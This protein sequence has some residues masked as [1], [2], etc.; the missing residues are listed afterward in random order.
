MILFPRRSQVA[1]AT[2]TST[3]VP[4]KLKQL[5]LNIDPVHDND[6]DRIAHLCPN[7]RRLY[8]NVNS[9]TAAGI[10]LQHY[11]KELEYLNINMY[12]CLITAPPSSEW[13][14]FENE[15]RKKNHYNMQQRLYPNNKPTSRG[16]RYLALRRFDEATLIQL[17]HRHA[18]TLEEL[19]LYYNNNSFIIN[20]GVFSGLQ[21]TNSRMLFSNLRVLNISSSNDPTFIL[22][23]LLTHVSPTT[24]QSLQIGSCNLS[25]NPIVLASIKELQNL[26]YL[27]LNHSIY[28]NRDDVIEL[29]RHFATKSR[30]HYHRYRR[31]YCKQEKHQIQQL[32]HQSLR[33]LLISGTYFQLINDTIL[34]EIGKI[35][36][37]EKIIIN[38]ATKVTEQGLHSFCQVLQQYNS[39]YLRCLEL[40]HVPSATSKTLEH[41]LSIPTLKTLILRNV[42]DDIKME[43]F[44]AFAERGI[45][46]GIYY[47]KL[48]I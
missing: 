43:D 42:A 5:V 14:P 17:L 28:A 9:P 8:I 36:T 31:F 25:N 45:H 12:I 13:S 39:G 34:Q 1:E 19:Y 35:E 48:R 40:N 15:Y 38:D 21:N 18:D 16:L 20:N 11:E 2:T 26:E 10:I 44:V 4:S 41:L 22:T 7:I 23:T 46:V 29:L 33:S 27:H 24:L 3:T 37:L 47:L 32:Q 6:V 30:S